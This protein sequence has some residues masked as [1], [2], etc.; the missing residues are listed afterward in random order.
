MSAETAT[1]MFETGK[2]LRYLERHHPHHPL[3]A[4]RGGTKRPG[5]EWKF[6]WED[7]ERSAQRTIVY[8]T[9]S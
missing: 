8:C 5:L 7:L 1:V 2:S 3:V 6:S 9:G 4:I